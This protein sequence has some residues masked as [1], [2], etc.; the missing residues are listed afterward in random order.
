M[1][2]MLLGMAPVIILA[3]VVLGI[4]AS[5]YVKA[6]PDT[7][8][9][10]SGLK[11]KKKILIGRA[12]IKIPF[13]ERLDKLNL[14]L[15]PLDIVTKD[16]VPTQDCIN[17]YV[18]AAVN[19]KI[20]AEDEA[21]DLAAQNF[22]N[23]SAE[24]IGSIVSEVLEGNVREIIC[25]MKLRELIGD[26]KTF[27]T[28]VSE[29]VIP[30]LEKMGIELVSFNVQ[31]FRDENDVINN[32]GIDNISQIKKD[33]AIA[34]ANANKEVAIA[35]SSADREANDARVNA[36][37]EIAIRNNELEIKKAELKQ[38]SDAKRA[39]AD[40]AYEIQKQEQE[41]TI[42]AATV[43]AQIARAEREAELKNKEVAVMQQ[44]LEAE[45]NKKADAERY[46]VEQKAAADLARRQR[47]AEAK[48]YE[49][50]K[51]AEAKKAQAE[52]G[53]YAMLQEAEGIKAKGE[54]EAAAIQAKGIAEA[55][56][57]EKKAEAYQKYNKVA[58][59][60][61]MIKVLPEIAGKIAEPL[62]QID[63][64][65][66]IGGGN[67]DS[68]NGI[69]SVAGN[70]PVVMAKLFESMKEATG[71]D[72]SEIMRAE[73][74]DA[75]VTKNLNITGLPENMKSSDAAGAVL[76]SEIGAEAGTEKK[77]E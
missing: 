77:T 74:Y 7:A 33:A 42:Q 14:K 30:D 67:G 65:T 12:G 11:R 8:Y 68:G 1:L 16:P 54:A 53:K 17:I 10:I 63:K 52:A 62:S 70:V 27:V 59:A 64:I 13:L 21:I 23:K 24:E 37:S 57:M 34:K 40:A 19:V 29:N 49:Q 61:M 45:I 25:T 72:L 55:E 38:V 69:S 36:E 71:V 73:T 6:P 43:N 31:N 20:K 35:Q 41:K 51:D 5:G 22:L 2:K 66:I 75:K 9:V 46:A 4:L 44:T 48:K 56:A 47:E 28:K 26:R 15:I 3:I 32:L 76:A 39:Q 60:E 18:D 58:M 50:E